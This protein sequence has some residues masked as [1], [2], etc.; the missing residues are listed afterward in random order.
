MPINTAKLRENVILQN[1]CQGTG[2]KWSI[3][4]NEYNRKMTNEGNTF[5][6]KQT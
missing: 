1:N 6:A 3:D 5:A 4:K 2:E